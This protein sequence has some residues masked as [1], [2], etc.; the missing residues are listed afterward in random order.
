MTTINYGI[1]SS[2][3]I[4]TPGINPV[5]H[6]YRGTLSFHASH[7]TIFSWSIRLTTSCT[8]PRLFPH[9]AP[10][11][12]FSIPN[13]FKPP[14]SAFISPSLHFLIYLSIHAVESLP[15]ITPL[16]H[17]SRILNCELITFT[18]YSQLP[19]PSTPIATFLQ[20]SPL[21]VP[22]SFKTKSNN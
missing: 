8:L 10:H 13:M 12:I 1:S 20:H 5:T 17:H 14:K 7:L 15:Y 3:G 9:P 16:I 18:K 19:L 2:L 21:S 11:R 6:S 4:H 22:D